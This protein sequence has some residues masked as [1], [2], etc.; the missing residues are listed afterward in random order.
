M[1]LP[2]TFLWLMVFWMFAMGAAV[3]SFL[4][5]VVYRLP[6][7]LSLI[8]PPSHC[9]KCGK[10]IPWYD[11][12][13]IFGWIILRGRCR[14]CHN[15]IS[16]RYPTIEAVTATMFALLAFAEMDRLNTIYPYHLLLLCTLLC[17]GLIEFDGNRPP[18]RLFLPAILIGAVAPLFLPELR[19][20][21]AWPELPPSLTGV[22]DGLAGLAAGAVLGSLAWL[23]RGKQRPVGVLHSLVCVGLVVGWQTLTIIATLAGFIELCLWLPDPIPL[24]RHF[25]PTIS[26]LFF[27]FFGIVVLALLT[28]R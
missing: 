11:N 1:P 12:V 15:P 10:G 17:A 8:Y 16:A 21:H 23:I 5:V 26:L 19:L 25:A 3:G 14:Q 9:P 28:L 2:D 18:L 24:R 6:L 7:G 22:I 13:P 4:N 27:T 20:W